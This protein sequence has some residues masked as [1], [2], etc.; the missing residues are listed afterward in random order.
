M[1]AVTLI[2]LASSSSSALLM[3]DVPTR[4]RALTKVQHMMGPTKGLQGGKS[5]C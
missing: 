3:L 2:F 5:M 4:P 1:L